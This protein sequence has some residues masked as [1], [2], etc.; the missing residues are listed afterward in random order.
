M[1][2]PHLEGTAAVLDHAYASEKWTVTS[3]PDG[4]GYKC[5]ELPT[6][7]SAAGETKS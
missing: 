3:I 2:I 1:M 5:W 7:A 4:G 6:V